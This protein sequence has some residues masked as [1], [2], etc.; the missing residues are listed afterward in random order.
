MGATGDH[1]RAER[2]AG[3][4]ADSGQQAQA[5]AGVAKVVGLPRAGHL[6]GE[7]DQTRERANSRIDAVLREWNEPE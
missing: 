4:I 1:K 7:A 2:I 6:L 5:L 3:T